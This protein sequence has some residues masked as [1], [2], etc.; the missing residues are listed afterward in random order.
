MEKEKVS[1]VDYTYNDHKMI[2]HMQGVVY[3]DLKDHLLNDPKKWETL[4]INRRKP[5]T[6]RAWTMFAGLRIC[7]HR[8]EECSMQE[9]F[10]HPHPWPG[11]FMVLEGTYRM[12]VGYAKDLHSEPEKSMT[13][14][15]PKGS[16]YAMTDP[17]IWHSVQPLETCYS[18]MVNSDPWGSLQHDRASTTKG[19]DLGRMTDEQLTEH[20]NKF[21]ELLNAR[22]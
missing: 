17:L 14:V 16:V 9:A 2:G 1:K 7:L 4:V 18:I 3:E 11:A 13:L 15:L 6:D 5:Y 19:E 12:K 22:V 8:F 21:K 10:F 20:L